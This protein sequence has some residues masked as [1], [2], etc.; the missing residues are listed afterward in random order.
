MGGAAARGF[1]SSKAD[2]A[3]AKR[4]K[5]KADRAA[6]EKKA[7]E[8]AEK[9]QRQAEKAKKK[10]EKEAK[11]KAALES[12][13]QASNTTAAPA[14][15]DEVAEVAEDVA[16]VDI[17]AE[18]FKWTLEEIQDEAVTK[19]MLSEYLLETAS[20]DF[21][22]EHKISKSAVKKNPKEFFVAAYTALL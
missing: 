9:E 2:A 19:K 21:K 16:A 20:D 11:E 15:S 7:Q 12:K 8:Q 10:E 17:S 18:G 13:M 4:E 22:E 5:T 6:R 1:D 3:A 14:E